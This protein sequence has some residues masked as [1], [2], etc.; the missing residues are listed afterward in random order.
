MLRRFAKRFRNVVAV[1]HS[2]AMLD[3]ARRTCVQHDLGSIEFVAAT[4]T[5]FSRENSGNSI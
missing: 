1:D 2:Q 3:M 4:R 5:I